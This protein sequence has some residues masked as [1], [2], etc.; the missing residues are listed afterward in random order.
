[1][2]LIHPGK[3]RGFVVRQGN[4]C[5]WIAAGEG[6]FDDDW[7]LK[8][9]D[10]SIAEPFG[11]SNGW[12]AVGTAGLQE[13][14]RKKPEHAARALALELVEDRA[15]AFCE[16]GP[17]FWQLAAYPATPELVGAWRESGRRVNSFKDQ[18]AVLLEDDEDHVAAN[19]EFNRQLHAKVREFE[20]T[21]GA[22]L[23]VTACVGTSPDIDPLRLQVRKVK[24]IYNTMTFEGEL[25]SNSVLLPELR[26][27]LSM[28]VHSD[29][30]QKARLNN[31][32]PV[33]RRLRAK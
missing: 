11:A 15:T 29:Y 14:D 23:E 13:E 5:I 24:R 3:A 19:R 1:M 2:E 22:W 26:A 17:D 18:G 21:P 25:I 6:K 4:A 7:R 33:E 10:H 31:E 27:G 28:E 30:I 16:R 8:K 32:E 9:Q 12:L 20:S